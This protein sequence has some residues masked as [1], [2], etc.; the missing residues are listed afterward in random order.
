M[1]SKR[2]MCLNPI[3]DMN[4]PQMPVHAQVKVIHWHYDQDIS[5]AAFSH[6]LSISGADIIGITNQLNRPIDQLMQL[7]DSA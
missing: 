1:F 7:C 6:K 4:S 2:W 5:N 3:N